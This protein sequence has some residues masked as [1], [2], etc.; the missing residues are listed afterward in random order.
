MKN[1]EINL[2]KKIK[3]ALLKIVTQIMTKEILMLRRVVVQEILLQKQKQGYILKCHNK[4]HYLIKMEIIPRLSKK[5]KEKDSNN[6]SIIGRIII[7]Y[8]ILL[9]HNFKV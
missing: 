9:K 6:I 7:L 2:R 1:K 3:I 8:R 5:L 4:K